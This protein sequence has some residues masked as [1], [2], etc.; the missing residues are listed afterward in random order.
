MHFK[1]TAMTLDFIRKVER[2]TTNMPK[3]TV[4]YWKSG[5]KLYIFVCARL[6][7]PDTKHRPRESVLLG[8]M[9]RGLRREPIAGGA[10]CPRV[11]G[12]KPFH[13]AWSNYV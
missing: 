12:A 6:K 11:I 1:P 7:A 13:S 8:L 5:P 3:M 10:R 9:E 4:M 2:K